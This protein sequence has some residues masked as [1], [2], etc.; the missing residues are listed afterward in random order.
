MAC[1]PAGEPPAPNSAPTPAPEPTPALRSPAHPDELRQEWPLDPAA[2]DR[3]LAYL[4]SLTV[5]GAV[6][7]RKARNGQ[8]YTRK[9]SP[10]T[11]MRAMRTLGLFSRLALRQQQLD[12]QAQAQVG[13]GFSWMA[14]VTETVN[15]GGQ[16]ATEEAQRRGLSCAAELDDATLDAIATQAEAELKAMGIDCSVPAG[17]PGPEE[18]PA[19][20]QDWVVPVAT[21]QQIMSRLVGMV[22]P[23]GDEF[24]ELRT[25]ERLMAGRLLGFFRRL[26]LE[27][28]EL[29]RRL[30]PAE[31]VFDEE[32]LMAEWDALEQQRIAERKRE[33]EEGLRRHAEREAQR[34]REVPP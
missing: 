24:A 9:V 34:Q 6:E 1:T 4:A 31:P 7:T 28:Q 18:D 25:R 11:A 10:R 29:D 19:K 12:R 5:R 15:L 17:P 23:Q 13:T 33:R 3:I 16:R 27:Q 8:E 14:H 21:K 32:Q 2:G 22:D 20:R 30:G 26:A